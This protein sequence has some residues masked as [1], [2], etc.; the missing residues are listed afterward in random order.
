MRIVVFNGS[1]RAGGNTDLLVQSA[2]KG[3]DRHSHRVDL[4]NL[5]DMNIKPCQN[6]G[7]CTDTG[8]CV[9][10]DRMQQIYPALRGADRIILASPIYFF[11]LSAQTKIMI[12]RCQPLWCEKYIHNMPLEGSTH[13]KGLLVL[14][15]GMKRQVGVDCSS[16]TATAF[17]RSVSV[18][19]HKTLAY[20]GIDVKG[21]ITS[22]PTALQ[23]VYEAARSLTAHS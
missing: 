20:L 11:G 2:L 14:V 12:D 16:A 23:D 9:V 3:I 18:E 19:E 5:N 6:C 7:G 10:D 15:G 8:V 21:A 22:H 1:P 17:F 13:R 4:F